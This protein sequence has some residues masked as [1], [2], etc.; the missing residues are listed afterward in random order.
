MTQAS[1]VA[2]HSF[3]S[4]SPFPRRF[5]ASVPTLLKARSIALTGPLPTSSVLHVAVAHLRGHSSEGDHD[6][7]HSQHSL[8]AR[9]DDDQVGPERRHVLVLTSDQAKWRDS[10]IRESDTSLFSTSTRSVDAS[11]VSYLDRVEIKHLPTSEHLLYFLTTVYSHAEHLLASQVFIESGTR[12][13]S[14]PSYLPTVPTL[15]V[16]HN[17]S[18][19]LAE[20][21]AQNDGIEAYTSLL[22]LFDSAF[23]R[24]SP[25]S[26][27][28]LVLVD[29]DALILEQA[30]L[31]PHLAQPRRKRK[32]EYEERRFEQGEPPDERHIE[33]MRLLSVLPYFYDWVGIVEPVQQEP[34][35]SQPSLTFV[36]TYTPSLH[37]SDIP[38]LLP[39]TSPSSREPVA[40]EF[41][42]QHLSQANGDDEDGLFVQVIS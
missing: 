37:S 6:D 5:D 18:E 17:P 27:P 8:E 36:M 23:T 22:A 33:Q 4:S 41:A 7:D 12:N 40:V 25:R 15:V 29:N 30:L 32:A 26:P 13:K 10:L 3:D 1:K 38:S 39:T 34:D 20:S 9:Q 14:D 11:F 24:L 35:P 42:V 19:Y 2:A 21:Q 31:A 16:L 28:L